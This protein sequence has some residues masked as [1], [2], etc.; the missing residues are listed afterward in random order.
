MDQCPAES[1]LRPRLHEVGEVETASLLLLPMAM[2]AAITTSSSRIVVLGAQ[3]TYQRETMKTQA[4]LSAPM[5][6]A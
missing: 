5:A 1:K 4:T 3:Q 2:P 6:R